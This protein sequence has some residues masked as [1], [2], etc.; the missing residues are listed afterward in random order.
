MALDP[1]YVP[2]LLES[3]VIENPYVFDEMLYY[4]IVTM[5]TAGYGDIYPR[6]A[7]G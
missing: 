7:P 5:T 6:T 3:E 4:S 1:N 2:T